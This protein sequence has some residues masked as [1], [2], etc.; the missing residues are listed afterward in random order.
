MTTRPVHLVAK[1]AADGTA[2]VEIPHNRNQQRD[3]QAAAS[4]TDKLSKALGEVLER[5]IG[6]HHHHDH[7]H[8]HTHTEVKNG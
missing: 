6:D 3:A 5:H 7:A 1:V 8:T 4:F 2:T